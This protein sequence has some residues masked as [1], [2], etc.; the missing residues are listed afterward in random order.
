MLRKAVAY[1]CMLPRN[2]KL[3]STM[4]PRGGAKLVKL[5]S[6]KYI[7]TGSTQQDFFKLFWVAAIGR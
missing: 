1:I 4:S 6:V 2:E 5:L 3:D 7:Y